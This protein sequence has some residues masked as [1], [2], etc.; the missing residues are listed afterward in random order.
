MKVAVIGAGIV[1]LTSA[2]SLQRAGHEVTVFEAKDAVALGASWGN[3]GLVSAASAE[4]WANPGMVLAGLKWLTRA[5]APL[6]IH[7][8]W[9]WERLSW[10]ARFAWQARNYEANTRA[11]AQ[12]ALAA[13]RPIQE[14]ADAAGAEFD[15]AKRGVLD[16]Y[17]TQR[18]RAHAER[19]STWLKEEGVGQEIIEPEALRQMEPSLEKDFAFAVYTPEDMTACSQKLCQALAAHLKV[20]TRTPISALTPL[21]DRVEVNGEGFD[22]AIICAAYGS[23]ALARQ[24]G[25]TLPLYP[26]KGYSLTLSLPEGAAA[27]TRGLLDHDGK[28]AVSRLGHRLRIGGTAE[29]GAKGR[30]LPP[31]RL[32]TLKDWVA[33]S[34][35]HLAELPAQGW[36]GHRPMAAG[37]LPITRQS[38]AHPHVIYNTGHGHLGWTIAA[39]S[40]EQVVGLV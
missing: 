15:L 34:L 10:L 32:K 18:Q 11:H 28:V 1:G 35:P 13:R 3:A 29:I 5:D 4:A 33:R 36:S 2:Y 19:L 9:D 39:A 21:A 22:R 27:P 14:L 23:K 7:L 40:A 25:D 6:K 31:A 20:Q 26:V 16:L 8:A 37:V 24:L 17:G 38:R 12:L 30:D